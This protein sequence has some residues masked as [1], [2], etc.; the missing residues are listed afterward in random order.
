VGQPRKLGGDY[1]GV[2]VNI[3]ARLAEAAGPDE[4]LVSDQVVEALG[5]AGVQTRRKRWFKAKGAPKDLAAYA[6]DAPG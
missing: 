6:V 1:L 4:I 5:D 2:D 3:A